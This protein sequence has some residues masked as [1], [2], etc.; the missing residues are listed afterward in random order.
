MPT[1]SA[2]VFAVF[3]LAAFYRL[4]RMYQGIWS[5]PEARAGRIF[6]LGIFA[7]KTDFTADE[8]RHRNWSIVLL[9]VGFI[10]GVALWE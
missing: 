8:W 7:P 1:L 6:R 10:L 3:L 4:A 2:V 5:R 9:L